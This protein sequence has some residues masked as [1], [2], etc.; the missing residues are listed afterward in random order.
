MP[1]SLVWLGA[2]LGGVLVAGLREAGRHG[3][4]TVAGGTAC[5]VAALALAAG[6]EFGICVVGDGLYDIVKHL[7]LFQLLYDACLFAALAWAAGRIAALLP[8]L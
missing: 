4:R 6:M 7:Y 8:R 3:A 1:R 2:F 5:L